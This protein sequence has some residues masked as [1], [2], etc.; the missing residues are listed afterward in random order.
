MFSSRTPEDLTPNR[1]AEAL[2]A[3]RAEG[4]TILDLT[5][6][7]P[8][9]AGFEYPGDLLR[10]LADPGGLT[11]T[12]SPFGLLDARAAVAR[13][14]ARR[15][16]AVAPERIALTASTSEAYACLFKL[17]TDPGD[18]V[19]IPRPGYPLFEHLASL[20][21]VGARPYDLDLDAGWR[22]D[23]ESLEAAITPHTRAIV[24]VSPNNPTGSFIKSDE[25][26]RLAEFAAARDLALIADEVFA[27]YEIT[28][29]ARAGAGRLVDR[30]DVLSFSL[31]G[32]S[33]SVGLPQVKLAWIAAAG[34]D[35]LID[36]A[37]G[38]LELICD[39]YLSVSTPVQL[40]AS[41]LLERGANVRDQIRRRV[42]ANYE[43]LLQKAAS[44]PA[45]RVLAT[46]GGWSAVLEVPSVY[47]EEALVVDLL[48]HDNVL[49]H[50][51]YFFDFL[52]ESYL[53][54]SLL[55]AEA[56]FADGIERVLRRVGV[57]VASHE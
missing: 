3:A 35:R 16:L 31:G 30:D 13:D 29:E 10:P 45:C 50:P 11:Y 22:I 55:V 18:E 17:L 5:Q 28:H 14:Y 12:P 51:G 48:Q 42:S 24:I 8:T 6:S 19:L 21:R 15:G 32:L 49:V 4:R 23:F 39:T 7:N 27:D 36:P 9:R 41:E 20:D 54:V 2:K 52:H 47:P 56:Q 25:V 43:R 26:D 1:L 40:A 53:V 44:L 37:L 34:P 38:R 33:K 46:E 57:P